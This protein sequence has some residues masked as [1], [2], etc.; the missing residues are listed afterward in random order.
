MY[1]IGTY[2]SS[3][4]DTIGYN[5]DRRRTNNSMML[6]MQTKRKKN[7]YVCTEET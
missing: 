1:S 2:L 4:H 5:K 7:D 3:S 6:C